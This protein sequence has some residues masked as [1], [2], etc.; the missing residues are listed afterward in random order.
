M[1][2]RFWSV[3]ALSLGLLA[4][5]WSQEVR[6]ALPISPTPGPAPRAL[7]VNP[8]EL[9][10]APG[11]SILNQG[12]KQPFLNQRP[13]GNPQ[14][15]AEPA[16][17]A[18]T[19]SGTA[20]EPDPKTRDQ[21]ADD[22]IRLAPGAG[23][24]S[25]NP[26]NPAKA[27]LAIA[28]G[29][30]QRKLYDLAVPEYEKYLGQYH[31]DSGRASA[32]YRLA[33]C[34]QSLGQEAP[35]LN[36][37][38]ML[39]DEIGTGEFVGSAAF[40]LASREFDRKA[41]WDAIPL[42]EKA[43]A[44]AKA[45]EVKLTARYYQAKCL[46]IA[47]KRADAQPLY[48]E[49]F[50]TKEKNPYRD[51][52]G[53]SL[54]Y[55]ELENNQKQEALD[56]FQ[57]LGSEAGKP[58]VKA[59]AMTRAG[60]LAG[61]LKQRDK[62]EQFFKSVIALSS[63]GK[64]KQIAWLELMKLE[65]EGDKFSQVLDSYSKTMSALSNETKPSVL[66]IVANSYRQLGKQQKALDVYNQLINQFSAS[67]EATDARFQ[68][69]VS[70]DATKDP[71]L[72]P[73]IDAFLATYPSR[74][75]AD[76]AKL[77]KAQALIQQNKFDPAGRLYLELADSSLPDSYKADCYYA[78]SYS[79]SQLNNTQGAINALSGLI[80][81]YPHYKMASKALLK[82]AILYQE[83][84][85][86]P[87]ALSDFS[88]IITDYGP[89]PERETALL[90]KGLTLGQQEN[91]QDMTATF[92]QLLKDYPNSA[93]AAQANYWIG[94]AAFESK[95][96]ADAIAPLAEARKRNP[97]EYEEKVSLRMIFCYQTLNRK[98]EEAKEIDDFLQKDTKRFPLVYDSCLWLGNSFYDEKNYA[99]AA[100]YL[101][102]ITKN[103]ERDKFDKGV[104][105]LLGKSEI[106]LKR[107]ADAVGSLNSYLELAAD[108][109]DRARGFLA[110]SRAQLGAQQFDGAR[111][112]AEQALTLQPE[113]RLNADARMLLGD[114]DAA[115]GNY[116][117]AARSYLSVAVLYEDPEV[118]PR[119]LEQAYQAF[120]QSG[121][122]SQATKTLS[123]L[124]SRFPNYQLKQPA[125]G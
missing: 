87:S 104:W 96:Y 21:V 59:E 15:T 85:N 55:F 43:Y 79:F 38:R 45:P 54:A 122:E 110:I 77:L 105:F 109:A 19:S 14:R 33:D 93:G 63:E 99:P 47:N 65:Y 27:Q 26:E 72:I 23:A 40:R 117:N 53:L 22:E 123:E 51:A 30:Y 56:R 62:A 3:C 9:P 18:P 48:E 90:Q 91:Y 58:A 69:L 97:E 114:V 124:K 4:Q 120:R 42:Y 111:Q 75:R 125:A 35:A 60:I 67:P 106:E 57:E 108:P 28:D 44:N 89:S 98:T 118:T 2:F 39:V 5:A 68:R 34:Y 94:W 119:A 70:L 25:Q 83:I 107:Y 1:T 71:S 80:E 84:K 52:A 95:R 17:T 10:Q 12:I 102:L 78:A 13:L 103:L 101:E 32:M 37:Y 66:M 50:K 11:D 31:D 29:L 46:E 8:S 92:S 74:D 76:K 20:A 41:Y 112:S 61:E 6:R 115:Q 113:G 7:P 64:W 73:E 88:K 24:Q 16:P 36:T 86:Y 82:R 121:D 81:K 49:V 116:A 100:K